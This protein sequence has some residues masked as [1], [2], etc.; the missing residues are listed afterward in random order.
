PHDIFVSATKE[1][2]A[3]QY[4]EPPKITTTEENRIVPGPHGTMVIH[5]WQ[6]QTLQ[7]GYDG[8]LADINA[9]DVGDLANRLAVG[10]AVYD[11]DG[12]RLGD[13][14]QYDVPRGLMVVEQGIFKP[15]ALLVPFSAIQSADPDTFT[16][17]LSL[18]RDVVVKE[19]SMLLG[20]A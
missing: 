5:T 17:Y 15:R 1:T 19:H 18:P 20:D 9:A 14:T 12:E 10:M 8:K 3:A 4:T 11:A 7:S 16:V 2:L 6:V 13:I